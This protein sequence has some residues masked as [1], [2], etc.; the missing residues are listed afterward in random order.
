MKRWGH[1]CFL[2]DRMITW[3]E[4]RW[5]E[6]QALSSPLSPAPSFPSDEKVLLAPRCRTTT[7]GPG[8]DRAPPPGL[9]PAVHI[10]SQTG[11]PDAQTQTAFRGSDIYIYSSDGQKLVDVTRSQWARCLSGSLC[12]SS[13]NHTKCWYQWE[14][15]L[16]DPCVRPDDSDTL[17]LFV[18]CSW[19]LV[20]D[21]DRGKH[22]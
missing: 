4:E 1:S 12:R 13:S 19:S 3:W 16:S 20:P 11:S 2:S 22:T 10:R 17:C 21:S 14:P 5:V 8:P 9:S 18:S 15:V 7:R 6:S